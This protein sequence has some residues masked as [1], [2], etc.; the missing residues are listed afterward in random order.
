MH[1]GAAN[2]FQERDAVMLCAP[3]KEIAG[4]HLQGACVPA[5]RSHHRGLW[6]QG[7]TCAGDAKK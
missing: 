2:A 4:L 7:V 5:A 1:M 6:H 3:K